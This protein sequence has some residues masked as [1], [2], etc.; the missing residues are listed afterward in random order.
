MFTSVQTIM[1]RGNWTTKLPLFAWK[2]GSS[3]TY[4]GGIDLKLSVGD[5]PNSAG[6][7]IDAIRCC[8]LALD[9]GVGRRA[10]F[11]LRILFKASARAN[12]RRRR[13]PL[14]RT[15]HLRRATKLVNV[16]RSEVRATP[17]LG[18]SCPS[19]KTYRAHPVEFHLRVARAGVV[20]AGAIRFAVPPQSKAA[21]GQVQSRTNRLPLQGA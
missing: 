2:A 6:V 21:D 10:A 14:R 15:I 8:K 18:G 1:C 12:D 4:T 16:E 17:L 20:S 11:Y 3:V 19:I 5:S 9:R 13:L 7:A